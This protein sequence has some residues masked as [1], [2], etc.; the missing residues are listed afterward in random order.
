MMDFI[1]SPIREI[2]SNQGRSH[3]VL[4]VTVPVPFR[5]QRRYDAGGRFE[6]ISDVRAEVAT[7]M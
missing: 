1:E 5:R 2:V 7:L 4:A 6:M 3:F